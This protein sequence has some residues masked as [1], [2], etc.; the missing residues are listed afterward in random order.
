[1]SPFGLYKVFFPKKKQQLQKGLKMKFNSH[2]LETQ[3]DSIKVTGAIDRFFQNFCLG[4]ILNQSGIRKAKGT[5]ALTIMSS[6]FA[7]TFIGK[8]FFRGIVQN[9]SVPFGKDAAYE[10]LKRPSH[11]RHKALMSLSVKIF[12]FFSSLTGEK[13]EKAFIIDDS[14]FDR[15]RSKRLSFWSECLIM[16]KRNL[17]GDFDSCLFAGR[18]ELACFRLILRFCH[19]RIKRIGFR[20]SQRLLT[21]EAAVTKGGSKPWIKPLTWLTPWSG[22]NSVS[23]YDQC[24]QY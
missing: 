9:Q 18:M 19:R 8:D 2:E 13:R 7:L 6:I 5:S 17:S 23:C 3:Q 21:K 20:A 10:L 15:S 4:T 1:M 24:W 11:N 22:S 16:R 12:S 14:P